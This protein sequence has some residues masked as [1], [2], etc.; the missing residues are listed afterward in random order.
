MGEAH[1]ESGAGRLAF[2]RVGSVGDPTVLLHGALDD[3]RTWAVVARQLAPS[4]QLLVVDRREHGESR[5]PERRAPVADDANDLARLLEATGD[6]PAHLVAQGYGG[7]VAL[8]LAGERPE[9]V[10]SVAAHDVPFVEL[11]GAGGNGLRTFL[12]ELRAPGAAPAP[13][14]LCREYL[15]LLGGP[16]EQWS[17]WGDSV[18]ERFLASAP[19]L[20]RELADPRS[21]AASTEALAEVSVPVLLTT[22]GQGPG[23]AAEVASRL[24]DALPNATVLALPGTGHLVQL[25]DPELFAGVIGTFLLERNVPVS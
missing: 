20:R 5:G 15:R 11:A 23:F 7:A 3:R 14:S 17:S 25:T 19:A 6:F 12:R 4:L 22:G 24:G 13:E 10:R 21:T 2:D 8:R 9:L 18:R 1:R 16:A